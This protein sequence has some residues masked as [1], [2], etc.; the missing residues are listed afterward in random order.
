MFK[1]IQVILGILGLLLIFVGHQFSRPFLLNGGIACLGLTSMAIGWEG[2]ITQHIV[3]GNRRRGNRQI[4]TGLAAICQ[5]IQFN[6]IGLVLIAAAFLLNQNM[7]ARELGIQWAR[8]PGLPLIALGVICLIQS[9]I[10]LIGP[11]E[12]GEPSF[13]M[14][15]IGLITRLL[16]GFILVLAGL[17]MI[18]LGLFEIAA[19]QAF[20]QMGGAFLESLYGIK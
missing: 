19:P 20:D 3:V 16:P 14:E 18:G 15:L 9:V 13:G 8:H 10:N 6:V 17:G 1:T 11:L 12:T 2:I 7:D 5:G 4:Y